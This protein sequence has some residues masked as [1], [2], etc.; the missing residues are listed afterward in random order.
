MSYPHF[1][2]LGYVLGSV[3]FAYYL[4]LWFKK[5]DVTLDT[6]DGNPGVFNCIVKA[7]K[8]LGLFALL[9]D[10]LKGAAPVFLAAHVVDVHRWPF[11]LVVAAPVVGHAFPLFRRFRGGKAITVSF[12]VTLG[13]LPM[14]EPFALL[15][16]SYLF[17][18]L[19]I[20]VRPRRHRSILTFLFFGVGSLL[21]LH[22]A[23]AAFGCLLSAA[24]VIF[25]HWAAEPEEE[26]ASARFVLSR[27]EK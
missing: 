19:I 11:V 17:F 14:W 24:V 23:P 20:Q 22:G 8:P 4:P 25:R 21:W 13:L 5:I 12:G 15:A 16:A 3:L 9:C 27:H 18:T 7:G 1:I 2:V 10:L 26:A 6:P